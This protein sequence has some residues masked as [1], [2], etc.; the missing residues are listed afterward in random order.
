MY[1]NLKLGRDWL[2]LQPPSTN[3][4]LIT[5]ELWLQE[6]PPSGPV[7]AEKMAAH[8]RELST[9]DNSQGPLDLN[10]KV[11]STKLTTS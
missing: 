1:L 3:K 7:D 4:I 5:P 6:N 9:S 2:V 8:K 10:I 11:S